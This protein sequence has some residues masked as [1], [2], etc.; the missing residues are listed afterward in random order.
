MI[1]VLIP[2]KDGGLD[3]VR[4]LEAIAQQEVDDPGRGRRRR[5][6]LGRR[7]PGAGAGTR[8][9]RARDPGRGVRARGDTQPRGAALVRRR[10][11]VHEPGRRRGRS[12]TGSGC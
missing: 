10:P 11:R 1:S 4:C 12:R 5:L 2:V 3:L 7:Q 8:G 9:D 6:R